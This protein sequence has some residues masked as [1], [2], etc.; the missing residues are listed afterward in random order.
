MRIERNVFSREKFIYDCDENSTERGSTLMFWSAPINE[1]LVLNS[2]SILRR[3]GYC[4]VC[5]RQDISIPIDNYQVLD[6]TDQSPALSTETVDASHNDVSNNRGGVIEFAT[7]P[8]TQSSPVT[9]RVMPH[10]HRAL[11]KGKW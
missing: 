4:S 3:N 10:A 1:S 8:V 9:P 5:F 11:A 7:K 6:A 2:R